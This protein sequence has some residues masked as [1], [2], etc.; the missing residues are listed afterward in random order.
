LLRRRIEMRERDQGGG[1]Q[2]EGTGARGA[3]A[4][5]GRAGPVRAGLGR[6][7]GQNP[8]HAQPQIGIPFAKQN[9]KR[10]EAIHVTKHDIRQKKI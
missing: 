2:G 1:A 10:N 4:E 3:W 6:T 5:A 8:R 7:A 9:T